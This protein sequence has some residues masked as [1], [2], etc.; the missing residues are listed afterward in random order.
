MRLN[1]KIILTAILFYFSLPGI[2]VLY[3]QNVKVVNLNDAISLAEKNNSD[4][5]TAR[6]DQ[7]KAEEKVSEVY[8][9]NLVPNLS[10]TGSY[11][12]YFKKPIFN[13][14]IPNFGTYNVPIGTD[15]TIT[16]A[17]NISEPIPILGTPVFSGIKIAQVYSNLQKE[18]VKKIET[19]IKADV[20]KA[21]INVLLLKEVVDVNTQSLS[22][23]QENLRVVEARYR[24]GTATE[25]DYLRA[26]V[27]VET[28]VPQLS[29]SQNN[30]TLSKKMLKTT[31]GLKTDD[32]IEASGSLTYDST[33]VYG[34]TDDLVNRISSSNVVIRQ[35]NLSNEINRE[36]VRVN[37]SSFLPKFYLFGQ[38]QLQ[39]QEDDGKSIF[40]YFYNNAIIA[41]LGM[42]W[43]L[44]FFGNNY[45]V[46]QS[47]LEVKKTD[48]QILNVKDQLKTQTQSILLR[49]DDAKK[50]IIA[51]QE[52]VSL[53]ERGLEL[54]NT[55]FKSGVINQIDVLDAE[56]SLS[57]VKL[58]LLQAIYDY[59]N[60]RTELVQLLE[61]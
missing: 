19:Q 37:R 26:K 20:T 39:A 38:Y 59:Q 9:E 13:I 10:L 18:N 35:L 58:S 44:N 17:L 50:R 31:I 4:L 48:E 52:T 46:N 29:Q 43:D 23:A 12:R 45:K 53:A 54:A 51:Q 40:G 60:A 28:L 3:A 61:K 57:Q 22:D 11:Q 47:Q 30:L 15:N 24:V 32:E 27:K 6:L 41:G 21:F 42:T 49:I 1:I 14:S 33:E 55:S 7:M 25:F 2:N 8:S 36:L 5:I 56:L 16:T 34:R